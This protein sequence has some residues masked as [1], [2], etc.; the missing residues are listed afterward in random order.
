MDKAMLKDLNSLIQLDIDA[1]YCYDEAIKHI[2]DRDIAT[3]MEGYRSDHQ[4]HVDALSSI[5]SSN[6]GTPPK[7]SPDMKGRLLQGMT[8]LRS[9][10]GTEGALKAMEMNE[11]KTNEEYDK[12]QS[13]DVPPDVHAVLEKNL[14]D[15]RRHLAY[16]QS[17]LHALV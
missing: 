11:K 17:Q 8:A 1:I 2:D 14:D 7:R 4:Q 9:A 12:A 13:W 10:T 16:V 5:V 15:E 3:T 6:G